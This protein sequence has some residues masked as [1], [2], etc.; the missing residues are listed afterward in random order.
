MN[1]QHPAITAYE[2]LRKQEPNTELLH[3][4]LIQQIW[5]EARGIPEQRP[6]DHAMALLRVMAFTFLLSQGYAPREVRDQLIEVMEGFER[7]YSALAKSVAEDDARPMVRTR[8]P[9]SD[10]IPGSNVIL[11]PQDGRKEK[12]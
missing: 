6:S 8:Q 4:A 5:F 7:E 11:F 12:R 2:A 3:F 10:V 1:K 9:G